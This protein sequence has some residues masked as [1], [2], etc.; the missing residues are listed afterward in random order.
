MMFLI[1]LAQVAYQNRVIRKLMEEFQETTK[2]LKERLKALGHTEPRISLSGKNLS[3]QSKQR[4][5][6][7]VLMTKGGD[8][9]ISCN[10]TLGD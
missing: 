10:L 7:D 5:M 8:L 1:N 3:G 9:N 4:Q 6:A 2:P